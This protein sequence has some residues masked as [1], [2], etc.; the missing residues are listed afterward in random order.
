MSSIASNHRYTIA[1]LIFGAWAILFSANFCFREAR[2]LSRTEVCERAYAH[3]TNHPHPAQLAR[4]REK[5][6]AFERYFR[7]YAVGLWVEHH[8]EVTKKT[9]PEGVEMYL[10][11]CG[12]LNSQFHFDR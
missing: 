1:A 7:R 11:S 2:F 10:C 3:Y 6:C 5:G 12:E 8:Q 9:K 4:I